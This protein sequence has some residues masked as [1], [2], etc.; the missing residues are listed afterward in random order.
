MATV[1]A[2]QEMDTGTPSATN[3]RKD[4]WVRFESDLILLEVLLCRR[5]LLVYF[6]FHSR[7][8]VGLILLH[9]SSFAINLSP[10]MIW[11]K[12]LIYYD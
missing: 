10:V 12:F 4:D 6:Q 9:P 11:T 7:F 1:A 8:A 3:E 5:C 2:K